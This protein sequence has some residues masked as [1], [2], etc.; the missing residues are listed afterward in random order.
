MSG[1]TVIISCLE[2]LDNLWMLGFIFILDEIKMPITHLCGDRYLIS[3]EI[4][5]G[6]HGKLSEARHF[7]YT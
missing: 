4:Q 5:M 7:M 3:M 6:K 1:V 2:K